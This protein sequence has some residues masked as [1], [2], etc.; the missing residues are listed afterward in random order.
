VP[1]FELEIS[2]AAGGVIVLEPVGTIDVKA[3]HTIIDALD[4]LR[5]GRGDTHVE[6][7]FDRARGATI[8]ALRVLA[9]R[10]ISSELL[11]AGAG[12]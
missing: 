11:L 8:D 5:G 1:T 9:T 12:A 3:A 2:G 6:L 7:R 10:H 4:T